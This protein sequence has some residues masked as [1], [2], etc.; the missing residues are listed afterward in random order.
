MPPPAGPHST[1][2]SILRRL[3]ESRAVEFGRDISRLGTEAAAYLG[4]IPILE[5]EA[6][7]RESPGRLEGQRVLGAFLHR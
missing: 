7:L 6:P 4:S 5:P 2:R 3:F 1:P